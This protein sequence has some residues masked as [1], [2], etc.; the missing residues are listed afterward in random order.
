MGLPFVALAKNG[1]DG[2]DAALR[3]VEPGAEAVLEGVDG[4]V[5]EQSEK[6][7]AFAKDASQDFWD[8]EDELAVG[9]FVADRGGDPFAG[10]ADATL[11]A[12]RAEK[13]SWQFSETNQRVLWAIRF[14]GSWSGG[15][16]LGCLFWDA[17]R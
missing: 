1:G 2:S 11:M 9:N 15:F 16:R 8:G 4:G 13:F 3:E 17:G 6:A 5:K 7:A 12:G 10:G 14:G